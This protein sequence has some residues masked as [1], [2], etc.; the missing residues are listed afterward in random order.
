MTVMQTPQTDEQR[1]DEI[2]KAYSEGQ[3]EAAIRLV[4]ALYLLFGSKALAPHVHSM[5]KRAKDPDHLRDKLMRKL[6]H[7]RSH[8]ESFDITSENLFERINDLAGVR[9]IHLYTAQ[10]PEIDR[11]IKSLLASESYEILEGPK[12]RVW[13]EEY[14]TIFKGFGI[15]TETNVRLYSSVHYIVGTGKKNARTAEIQ[16]RTIAE[17]LWG[18]VDHAINYPHK[19]SVQTCREQ[20]KVLARVTSSCTRL[21]DSI[22][23]ANSEVKPKA[24]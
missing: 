8:G 3:M 6:D 9:I 17:E 22:F 24:D 21:V 2:V 10:F 14:D 1:I 13:D 23:L 18:E 4:E 15:E 16:V 7:C 5:K 12:A 20:I 11:Q 19:C